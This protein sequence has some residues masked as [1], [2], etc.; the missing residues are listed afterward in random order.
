MPPDQH[1]DRALRGKGLYK[2]C[3]AFVVLE[4]NGL[5]DNS[6][7]QIDNRIFYRDRILFGREP[8]KFQ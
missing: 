7:K 6:G 1:L 2:V 3:A 8:I 4:S 5:S